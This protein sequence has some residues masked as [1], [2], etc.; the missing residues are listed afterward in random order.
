MKK[1]VLCLL[2]ALVV[3]GGLVW[4][5]ATRGP[6][7]ATPTECA[8]AYLQAVK[9]AD[10]AGYLTCLADEVCAAE[11]QRLPADGALARELAARGRDLRN[12]VIVSEAPAA[13]GRA[14]V[15]ADHQFSSGRGRQ[16]LVLERAGTA[17]RIAELGPVQPI[18]QE[19]PY[20]THISQV[21]AR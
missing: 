9:A 10:A 16:K 20:G 13:E 1:P 15:W 21:D 7:F 12:W 19:V 5:R 6:H 18:A 14:V 11:R 8:E 17:W 2:F 3:A 4:L